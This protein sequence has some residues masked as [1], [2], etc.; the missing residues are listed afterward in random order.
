MFRQSSATEHA[1]NG[2]EDASDDNIP[3]DPVTPRETKS[4]RDSR[5][6]SC[7]HWADAANY[8]NTFA[9]STVMIRVAAQ[10]VSTKNGGES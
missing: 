7:S 1:S 10:V 6:V 2:T 8:R 5:T 4:L 3:D 9:A